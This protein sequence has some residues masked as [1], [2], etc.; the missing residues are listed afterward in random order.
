MP[1]VLSPCYVINIQIF[2]EEYM[3][4]RHSYNLLYSVTSPVSEI[5]TPFPQAPSVCALS[6]G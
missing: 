6:F 1:S 4:W 3:L 5:L 2:G